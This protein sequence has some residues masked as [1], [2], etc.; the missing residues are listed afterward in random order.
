MKFR[1]G[2]TV[3]WRGQILTIHHEKDRRKKK[4]I[5]SFSN[6]NSFGV[7]KRLTIILERN[8]KFQSSE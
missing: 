7:R 6:I 3:F 1:G 4:L 2:L 8:Y 5:D